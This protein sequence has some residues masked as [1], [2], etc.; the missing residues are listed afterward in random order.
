MEGRV[1]LGEG[2]EVAGHGH[3]LGQGVGWVGKKRRD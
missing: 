3:L 2:G 1:H